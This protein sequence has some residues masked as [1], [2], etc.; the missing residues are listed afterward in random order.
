V[1]Y[2]DAVGH[3][4]LLKEYPLRAGF[5]D[6]VA[7]LPREELRALQNRR[8]LRV[9]RRAWQVPFYR[10]RWTEAGVRPRDVRSLDEAGRLPPYTK[11]DLMRSIE[12]DPPFG[13][14]HGMETAPGMPVVIHTTSGT[15]GQPQP[16]FYGPRSRELQNLMLARAYYF[17]GLRDTD[18]VHSVYGHGM[19]NGGHYIRETFLHFTNA[20]FFSAGTGVE[21][22]SRAQVELLRR[23]GATVLVGFADYLRHLAE[24]ARDSGLDPA[25]DLAVRM[26][27]T[28]LGRESRDV[29]S[30]AWGGARVFDWYGVGDTGLIAAEGPDHAGLYLMEDAHH[31]D[32]IHPDT[33]EVVRAG[34]TGNVC[35]T[36]LFKDDIFP[37]VRFDTNDLSALDPSPAALGLALRRLRGFLGRSDSMVKLRGINV[38]PTAVGELLERHPDAN[39]EFLCRVERID[40]RDEMTVLIETRTPDARR[41]DAAADHR[42][43]LRAKLGV[44]VGVELVAPGA[45][46]ALTGIES[47]QKPVRLQDLR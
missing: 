2:F 40:G 41:A 29:L 30:A 15:T 5:T 23:F 47:R 7:Q 42:A 9:L 3:R 32:L 44:E 28:H 46:A 13:D 18:R 12:A 45:L 35:V 37:V 16:L 34:D 39:G 22:R 10:R 6:G 36:V 43:L 1:N 27:S 21:T 11:S 8:F 38:Y 24:V 33:H 17:Q 4:R 19:V 31:V 14:F 20:L 26:I 25:R